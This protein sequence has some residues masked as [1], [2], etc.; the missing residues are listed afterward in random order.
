[1]NYYLGAGTELIKKQCK[2]YK[3]LEG[4]LKAAAKDSGLVAWDESGKVVGSL[5]DKISDR[6]NAFVVSERETELDNLNMSENERKHGQE[7]RNSSEL[8]NI[9]EVNTECL[10]GA[11]KVSEEEHNKKV[12]LLQ[13]AMKVT[14]IC[15][16][17]LNLRRS[18]SWGAGNE[19]GR[20]AKGQTY[21]VKNI[22][23]VEGR[24]MVETVDG[25]FLS[26]QREHVQIKPL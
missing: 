13:G 11:D 22:H 12:V 21:Y 16:G 20:A 18:A 26:G 25:L 17:T 3:T 4:V 8:S 10:N 19:C 15:E 23:E 14:V 2:E 7:M 1:M 6:E 5:M 24:R 9:P